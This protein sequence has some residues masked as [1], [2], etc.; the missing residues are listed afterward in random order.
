MI[1][2]VLMQSIS[3]SERIIIDNIIA[4]VNIPYPGHTTSTVVLS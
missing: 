3:S 4:G 2:W 1:L